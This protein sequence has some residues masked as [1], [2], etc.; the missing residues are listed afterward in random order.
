MTR[1][2]QKKST[3][4][5]ARTMARTPMANMHGRRHINQGSGTATI[6]KAVHK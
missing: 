2:M 1:I 4:T 5:M 3:E 6:Q